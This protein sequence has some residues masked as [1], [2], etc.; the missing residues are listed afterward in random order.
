MILKYFRKQPIENEIYGIQFARDMSATDQITHAWQMISRDSSPDWDLEIQEAPYT[1]IVTDDDRK[2]VTN[3]FSITLPVDA[4]DGFRLNVANY[5]QTGSTTVGS[6][7]VPARGSIVIARITGTWKEEAKTT[8]I[9]VD[10]PN[11]QRVRT[12]M[13]GGTAWMAYKIDVTV[14]TTEDRTLQ[15]E[16]VV[17]IEEE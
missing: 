14:T 3:G 5:A 12:R 11:D 16:F 2:I 4:P 9:L 7:Q 6:F 15:N 10:A 13:T 1:A 8:A 17:E